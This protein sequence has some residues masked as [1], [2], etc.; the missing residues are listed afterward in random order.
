M[1]RDARSGYLVADGDIAAAAAALTSLCVL[2]DDRLAAMRRS[3][4]HTAQ[5]YSEE[6]VRDR[7]SEVQEAAVRRHAE[8]RRREAGSLLRRAVG[9]ALRVSRA[10]AQALRGSTP[11]PR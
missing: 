6:A 7:W 8:R 10:A 9:R 2:P 4:R 1:I 11:H 5:A 3:A